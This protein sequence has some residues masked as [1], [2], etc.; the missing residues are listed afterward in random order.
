M[1]ALQKMDYVIIDRGKIGR[2]EVLKVL[3]DNKFEAVADNRGEDDAR[4]W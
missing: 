4:G 3:P 1:E 2:T